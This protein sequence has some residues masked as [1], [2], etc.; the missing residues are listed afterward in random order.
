MILEYLR[1]GTDHG[2][3]LG[4]EAGTVEDTWDAVGLGE[5]GRVGDSEAERHAEALQGTEEGGGPEE[6]NKGHGKAEQAAAQ[7]DETQFASWCH[8]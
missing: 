8:H 3:P 1:C 6:E 2:G 7:Q 4:W 5:E